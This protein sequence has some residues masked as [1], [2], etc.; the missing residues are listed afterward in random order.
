MAVMAV[1]PH[2]G[3][4]IETLPTT[5]SRREACTSHPTRVRG[6]K[7]DPQRQAGKLRLVAPHAGAWI[8]TSV[9]TRM[10]PCRVVAPHAGAWIE[11]ISCARR[12][13]LPSASHPTRVRGLK[14]A[15]MDVETAR[16]AG[17][18]PRGCVD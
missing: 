10:R 4:W 8:E 18:T 16:V 7:H 3:A 9:V 14:L 13:F 2:A 12:F 1:A 6:L 5:R 17:R 11:T 15:L